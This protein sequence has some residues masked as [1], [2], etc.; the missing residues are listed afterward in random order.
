MHSSSERH[1]DGA[2]TSP[3]TREFTGADLAGS[4]APAK[5]FRV[6]VA[7]DEALLRF[8]PACRV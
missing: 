5:R 6:L 3:K 7:D 4:E 8:I 2:M 1:G